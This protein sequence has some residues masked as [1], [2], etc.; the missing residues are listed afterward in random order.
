MGAGLRGPSSSPGRFRFAP[1]PKA[2]TDVGLVVEGVAPF[3]AEIVEADAPG[4][5]RPEATPGDPTDV[6]GVSSSIIGEGERESSDVRSLRGESESETAAEVS[7]RRRDFALAFAA[8][9]FVVDGV[10][11]RVEVGVGSELED[12]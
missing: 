9:V 3:G 11:V 4:V 12:A 10:V 1:T 8:A 2:E 7:T 6:G 5:E